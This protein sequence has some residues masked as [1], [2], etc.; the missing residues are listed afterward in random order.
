VARSTPRIAAV[1]WR[2]SLSF[3]LAILLTGYRCPSHAFAVERQPNLAEQPAGPGN[4][5]QVLTSAQMR[6]FQLRT[7]LNITTKAAIPVLTPPSEF[8]RLT[9]QFE[10]PLIASRAT[11]AKENADLLTTLRC[12][13]TRTVED[14]FAALTSFLTG[15]PESPWRVALLTNLGLLN[16]HYGYFSRALDSWQQAWEAGKEIAE[17]RAR[18]LVDRAIGEL[19]RMHAR[20]GHANELDALFK[21]LGDR[22]VSGPATEAIA[23]AREGLVVMRTDPGIAYLCGPMALKNLLLA[24][25]RRMKDIA[26]LDAVRSGPHGV[27]L[28][29]VSQLADRAKLPHTVV[30]RPRDQPIPVP[31]IIHWRVSH[32]AA[33]IGKSGNRFHI[34]D[35]TFGADLWVTK[36][37]ID[38]ESD[39][40]FLMANPSRSVAWRE[41]S[42]A[43]TMQVRG[44][45]YPTAV[46]DG[47]TTPKDCSCGGDSTGMANYSFTEMVVSLHI[48]DTPVGYAPPK[49]PNV[50]VTLN[51]NQREAYQPANFIYFNVSPKWTLNWLSYIQDDPNNP[52]SSVSRYVAGGGSIIDYSSYQCDPIANTC[53]SYDAVT[54]AF[55]RETRDGS[56]LS[57]TVT[58]PIAYHRSLA[59]GSVEIYSASNSAITYPR[60]IFLTQITDPAGNSVS[61]SYD[62]H[63]RLTSITDATGRDTTF[64]YGS[65][66]N[67]LL[68]TEITDPFG[69]SAKL[70]YD[71]FGHLSQITDVL[72]LKSQFTYDSSSL[73]RAMVTPYGTTTFTF[74]ENG[75]YRYLNATD[76]LG[77]TERVEWTQP[78]PDPPIPFSEPANLIPVGIINPFNEFI[79]GRSTFYWDKH[80]YS[81]G[82]GDYSRA[83]VRH[84]MHSSLSG[85][86]YHGLE[87]YKYPLEN[88]V[89]LNY[90]GQPNTGFSGTL[91]YPTRIGRV[92]DDGTTQLTQ[93]NYN[94]AG[95]VTDMID[96]VGRETTLTYDAN[97]IDL[98]AVRQN[99]SASGV[100]TIAQFT[101]NSQHLP[102]TYTDA[103]GQ[104][105]NF[106]YNA[107]G[108]LTQTTNA[109]RETTKY[110]YDGLGYLT[111][112]INANGKTQSSLSYD[113]EGRVATAT[114]SEGYTIAYGYDAFDR[115]TQETFPDSTTRKYGYTNLDLTSVTDRQQ[116][117]TQYAYDAIRDLINTTDALGHV[118]RFGYWENESLK[119]L[120]DPNGN[121]TRWSIDVQS[122]VTG[123]Q[124][125]D[126]AQIKNNYENTTSRLNSI[127]DA[128]GQTKQFTYAGDDA[129]TG[130]AYLNTVNP[131]PN[132]VFAYDPYFRRITSMTDGNGVRA[133][134]YEPVGAAGA[135]QLVKEEGP[136]AND[137]ITY[138]FDRLSR[139]SSRL[140]DT[141]CE[142]FA[143]DRLSRLVT[144]GTALGTFNLGYLGQTTQITSQQISTGTVGTTWTYDSNMNDRRLTAIKNSGATRSFNYTST[145]E[146]LITQIQEIAPQGSAWAPKT[147]NYSYDD[148]YRLTQASSGMETYAYG[149]D[150]SDNITSFQSPSSQTSPSYN[151]LNQIV[152]FG[153]S[154]YVYDKNGNVLN[155][156]QRTYSWDAENR[157]LSAESKAQPLQKTTFRYDGL[158]RRTAIETTSGMTTETRYLWC[159][160]QVCQARTSADT[161]ERRYYGEGEY[162]NLSGTSLYYAEDQLGSVRDVLAAQ[163]GNRIASFDYDSYGAITRVDGRLSTDFRYAG[164]FYEQRSGLNL[165]QFR[166]YD[167][168]VGHWIS[169][170][171]LGDRP[172]ERLDS[173]TMAAVNLYEYSAGNPV[174]FTDPAGLTPNG[175]SPWALQCK[176]KVKVPIYAIPGVA[177]F[178]LDVSGAKFELKITVGTG[179]L[180]IPIPALA[181]PAGEP[182]Q[183]FS[184]VA[185]ANLGFYTSVLGYAAPEGAERFFPKFFGEFVGE[186]GMTAAG[187]TKEIGFWVGFLGAAAGPAAGL[188]TALG[189]GMAGNVLRAHPECRKQFSCGANPGMGFR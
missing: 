126:G 100:S 11:S 148:A 142:T 12:Y 59:D 165:T 149:L 85:R 78:A 114:D 33:L 128:L 156:G 189:E 109:L 79:N 166:I 44:M 160:A 184:G 90:P 7:K 63:Q 53:T 176:M 39:G 25:H 150:A 167:A 28:N 106:L 112:I 47:A 8:T 107:A 2:S 45:G 91:D 21:E 168:S 117:A 131:T 93:L 71:S 153:N 185:E 103:A 123:K 54:G 133:Y 24:E 152:S 48:S 96:P 111:T 41:A 15:H 60:L 20:L 132:V 89:W 102:L 14:D 35:P 29:E 186:L 4:T 175:G 127:T 76:P 134:A 56:V 67:P 40:Y 17:P 87:S 181:D 179:S 75:T 55:P 22:H 62:N 10:E 97:Q 187:A 99:T 98:L 116:N 173:G 161:V 70:D 18:A 108:Q 37:A 151:D 163:S 121:T 182:F 84:W 23:G 73:I 139:L 81:V 125:A 177:D 140:V 157:L 155:D 174:N 146:K 137:S 88:R 135:L 3:L 42:K 164:T 138:Q 19:A 170:D 82:A 119:S 64:T 145:P 72:G 124:Y 52:G 171:P 95:H 162:R 94:K 115:V 113:A 43:E 50:K 105:T 158:G 5:A 104:T 144:H 136:Y 36:S 147:W 30:F 69:R 57:R 9:T 32:F 46:E 178:S 58:G 122:R 169:R 130:V 34:I 118:T 159:G 86:M 120:T 183:V 154:A 38:T 61:L 65:A 77:H 143:Y 6:L 141:D 26:F 180:S 92:L 49:G 80:A 188:G 101:Y 68:V 13:H 27:T 172:R 16:Y 129:L 31:S 110:Q 83:R 66:S 51:Y 74:G 1:P